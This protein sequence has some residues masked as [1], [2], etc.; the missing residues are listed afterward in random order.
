MIAAA[1][2]ASGSIT[3]TTSTPCSA[4][5][6]RAVSAPAAVAELQAM[7]SSFAPR[8]SRKRTL[9]AHALAQLFRGLRAVREL[10]V[11]AE[12]EEV[13][14]GQRDEALVQD[15]EAPDPGV[16]DRYRQLAPGSRLLSIVSASDHWPCVHAPRAMSSAARSGRCGQSA[17]ST[18][19][20]ALPRRGARRPRTGAFDVLSKVAGTRLPIVESEGPRRGPRRAPARRM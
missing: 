12:V 20:T 14:G 6:S 16:E 8:S 7:T 11:V 4:A 9:R 1:I 10:G 2:S 5:I 18:A 3:V 17:V 13:L 19:S 15:R